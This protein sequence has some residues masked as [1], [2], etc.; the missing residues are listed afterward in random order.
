M[1]A[2]G[3]FVGFEGQLIQYE[4]AAEDVGTT[5]TFEI[6]TREGY[7]AIDAILFATSNT[8]LDDFTQRQLDYLI[9]PV[10]GDMDFDGDT[11]FDD[12][13]DFVLGLNDPVEYESVYGVTPALTGDL[14]DDGD[15]DFDDI[16]G[17]VAALSASSGAAV[18]EPSTWAL[19]L[20]AAGLALV[21]RQ[22]RQRRR[23]Y[24]STFS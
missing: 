9:S 8:L 12:I 23:R 7:G 2:D 22:Y 3:G 21:T 6:S 14:D 17:F 15:Q 24:R 10:G 13:D 19:G 5:L 18:P 20:T 11:D 16:A 1:N 4:V